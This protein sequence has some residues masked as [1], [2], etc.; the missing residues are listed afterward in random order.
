MRYS[1]HALLLPCAI[2]AM[3]Y[4]CKAANLVLKSEAHLVVWMLYQLMEAPDEPAQC[5]QACFIVQI[6]SLGLVHQLGQ[7]WSAAQIT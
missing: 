5:R 1:C 7:A 6:K 3:C 2:L 4:S